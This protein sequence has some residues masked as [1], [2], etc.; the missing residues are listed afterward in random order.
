[1]VKHSGMSQAPGE[2]TVSVVET[3]SDVLETEIEDIPPLSESVPI[4]ALNSVVADPS[5]DVT[6]TFSYAGLWVLVRS[7][8][9]VYAR[10]VPDEAAGI[11]HR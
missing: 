9:T 7:D 3:A 10:P 2:V 8:G 1:M 6:V 4:D 5:Q 11:T